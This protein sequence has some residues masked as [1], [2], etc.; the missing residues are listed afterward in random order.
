MSFGRDRDVEEIIAFAATAGFRPRIE[1][2][3]NRIA[4]DGTL[5]RDSDAT[6][7]DVRSNPAQAAPFSQINNNV[8]RLV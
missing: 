2:R 3:A 8:G 5:L 6:V 7:D 1:I 4:V